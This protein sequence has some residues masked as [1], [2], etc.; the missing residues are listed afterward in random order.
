MQ[1]LSISPFPF[2]CHRSGPPALSAAEWDGAGAGGGG[3]LTP[4]CRRR[5]LPPGGR[6]ESLSLTW[7]PTRVQGLPPT[8][9]TSAPVCS[10]RHMGS[11]EGRESA[12]LIRRVAPPHGLPGRGGCGQWLGPGWPAAALFG[13]LR[14]GAGPGSAEHWKQD[15]PDAQKEMREGLRWTPFCHI[16]AECLSICRSTHRPPS[17]I[18]P[19]LHPHTHFS[20]YASVRPP[21]RSPSFSSLRPPFS[22][23]FSHS[24][25][26]SASLCTFGAKRCDL[27]PVTSP[28]NLCPL[29]QLNIMTFSFS[30]MGD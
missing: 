11:W 20:L 7:P 2:S 9:W 6:L 30:V 28:L 19:P 27:G 1:I 10:C 3:A 15:V 16:L 17:S 29:M 14:L 5:L 8:G 23:P 4:H 18:L 22:F 26:L 25:T 12:V 13:G 24:E 21:A